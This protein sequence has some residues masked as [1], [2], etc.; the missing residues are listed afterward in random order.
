MKIAMFGASGTVG[1]A[2]LHRALDAGHDVHC[3]AR[4][5]ANLDQSRDGFAITIGDA[6]STAA[7]DSVV[8]G[9][10]AVIS[11]LGGVRG[12]ESLS[13]GTDAIMAA[14]TVHGIRR[15]VAIQGFHLAFPGDPTNLGQRLMG[16]IMRLYNSD[17]LVHSRLMAAALQRSDLNWTLVRI[18]R[19]VRGPSRGMV[20]TG[21]LRLGPWSTVTATDVAAFVL[22]CL[23]GGLFVKDA[24]MVAR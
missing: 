23:A 7:V 22:E 3:L 4:T 17:I 12:P 15:L 13:A 18:P 14:M 19:V 1:S 21:R 20:R 24:P 5:A 6:T 11:A 8:A 9:S 10:D 2:V 16:P